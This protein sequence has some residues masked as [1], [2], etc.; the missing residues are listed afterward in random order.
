MAKYSMVGKPFQVISLIILGCLFLAVGISPVLAR[1]QYDGMDQPIHGRL[2]RQDFEDAKRVVPEKDGALG[3]AAVG[4]DQYD[5]LRHVL[6]LKIDPDPQWIEG[7]V[8]FEFSSRVDNMQIMVLDLAASLEVYSVTST[9]GSLTFSH[10]ADS[11]S[12]ILPKV[13]KVDE[14]GSFTVYYRGYPEEPSWD[15]GLLFRFHRD[16]EGVPRQVPIVAN[17]SEPAYAKY[18]WPCKDKPDDKALSEVR[19]TVPDGLIGISNGTLVSE[20]PASDPG[21]NTNVWREDYPIASYLVSVAVS[22][23]ELIE[24]ICNTT[25]GD[26]LGYEIPLKNWVFPWHYEDAQVDFAPLCDM[27]EFCESHFGPY[28][29]QGEKYGHAEFIWGGA[30]EHQTVTSIGTSAI[31]GDGS[32]DWLIVHELAH[33]WFGNHL[34]P[35]NWRDIWLNEGFATYSESLWREHLEGPESYFEN[36]EF[37]RN[38]SSWELQGPVYDPVPVFPGKVIYD[39][40]AWILHMLRGRM[41]DGPFFDLLEDW[42]RDGGLTSQSVGVSPYV[43][44]SVTTQEFITLA[45]I[46]AGQD[47]GGFFWPYLEETVLPEIVFDYEIVEG[48]AGPRTRLTA[49]LRQV[50]R[51]LFDNVFPVEVVTESGVEMRYMSLDK[52]TTHNVFEF[53]D[54]IVSV[55]LDP[56]HWVLWKPAVGIGSVAGIT[57]LYPNPSRGSLLNLRY[58]LENPAQVVLRIFDAA[59]R[60]VFIRDLGLVVPE[61]GFNEISW[62]Q[63]NLQ[64]AGLPSG[65]YWATLEISGSRSVR[66]FTIIR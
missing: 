23:Y 10:D 60:E 32:T 52:E 6:D 49:A 55:D 12:I 21:W 63:N 5:M 51:P 29:F 36:L 42:G 7:H 34:T 2:T 35:K 38:E 27:M 14:E 64:G 57:L 50:Q 30:M 18:W 33:Q 8:A 43:G 40:G 47:L 13:L 17:M 20:G 31:H 19:I 58:F 9:V 48:D 59:G 1:S 46:H 37:S 65:I 26:D 61:P 22:D 25:W 66:K 39:K 16:A 15:R 11:L 53:G 45:E 54:P 28:P 3:D 41:G 56:E 44:Y 62:N 4:S 24:S